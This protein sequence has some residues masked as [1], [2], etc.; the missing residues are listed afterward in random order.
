MMMNDPA[1]DN[2]K[3]AAPVRPP[4]DPSLAMLLL[5]VILLDSVNLQDEAGKVTDRDRAAVSFLVDKTDW[6]H[7]TCFPSSCMS[8]NEH[9]TPDLTK[10]FETLQ[11]AKFDRDFWT[12]LSIRD[13]LRLDYKSFRDNTFGIA[14]VLIS[15]NDFKEKENLVA[16]LKRFVDETQ[17][18]LLI[19]MFGYQ[20]DHVGS[21]K[22]ELLLYGDETMCRDNAAE[23]LM[24]KDLDLRPIHVG[25]FEIRVF[26][27]GNAKASRKQVAP[28]VGEF[29]QL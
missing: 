24:T 4:H 22:R 27:Q 25:D 19:V 20:D 9:S 5:G 23:F 13:A 6:T 8:K 15:W 10:V 7:T 3:A 14:S 16:G 1:S 17:T 26:A 12:A 2:L 11:Q 29:Y 18:Q 28:L 21:L